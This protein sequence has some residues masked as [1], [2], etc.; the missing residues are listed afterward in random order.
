MS[1]SNGHN[2]GYAADEMIDQVYAFWPAPTPAPPLCPEA[3]L[4]LTLKGTIGGI[5]AMMTVRGQS[6]AEFKANFE[7]IKGLLDQPQPAAGPTQ[8]QEWCS[9]HNV[10]LHLNHGKDGRTWYSHRHQGG[11]CKGGR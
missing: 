8:G 9:I 6:P 5:E 11:F 4:S 3:G 7:A 10:K 1:T 2:N